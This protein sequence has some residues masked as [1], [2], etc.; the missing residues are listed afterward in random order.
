MLAP[1]FAVPTA[2]R[3][4]TF[5]LLKCILICATETS[6]FCF[7]NWRKQMYRIMFAVIGLSMLAGSAPALAERF[8]C[9]AARMRARAAGGPVTERDAWLLKS[10]ECGC[11]PGSNIPFCERLARQRQQERYRQNRRHQ[12][13]Y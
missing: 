3:V 10:A 8:D 12:R 6:I 2:S 7:D 9:E 1:T 13:G 4:L 11:E 5:K